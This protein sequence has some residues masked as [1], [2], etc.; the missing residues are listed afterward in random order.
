M[1]RMTKL[2]LWYLI[3]VVVVIVIGLINY[4]G[5]QRALY[6]NDF[7]LL[8]RFQYMDYLLVGTWLTVNIIVLFYL[9]SAKAEKI[10][11]IFPVYYICIHLFYITVI[12]ASYI[13]LYLPQNIAAIISAVTSVFEIT[14]AGYLSIPYFK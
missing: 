11:F 1:R 7:M 13:E 2:P 6:K 12:A 4:F 10:D 5:I 3:G 9:M 14:F 8:L